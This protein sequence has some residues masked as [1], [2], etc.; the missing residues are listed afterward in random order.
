[1]KTTQKLPN[2]EKELIAALKTKLEKALLASP[3]FHQNENLQPQLYYSLPH[4]RDFTVSQLL[5]TIKTETTL[6]DFLLTLTTEYSSILKSGETAKNSVIA[7]ALKN[8]IRDTKALVQ[9]TPSHLAQIKKRCCEKL[10]QY[11]GNVEC[12]IGYKV[13]RLFNSNAHFDEFKIAKVLTQYCIQCKSLDDLRS[14]M[15]K[16]N[17]HIES[18]MHTHLIPVMKEVIE[19]I[20]KHI[21][22][23]CLQLHQK[24]FKTHPTKIA[25]CQVFYRKNLSNAC[26]N[27]KTILALHSSRLLDHIAEY[28]SS[29]IHSWLSN[30]DSIKKLNTARWFL[31]DFLHCN[32]PNQMLELIEGTWG[33]LN[34]D[35]PLRKIIWDLLCDYKD[36]LR[37]MRGHKP[38]GRY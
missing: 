33:K 17:Q 12:S 8:C 38:L 5:E 36:H 14:F 18:K 3:Y 29:L 2:P 4:S 34:R 13:G 15:N 26:E 10:T 37:V 32:E 21:T 19:E 30:D 23:T 22:K 35:D 24:K 7:T 27:E 11:I 20:G 25:P 28:E 16:L 9:E 1:M 6:E 31:Y